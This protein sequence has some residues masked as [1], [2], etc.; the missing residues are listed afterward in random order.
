M[1]VNS[2]DLSH[3]TPAALRSRA[4]AQL[5]AAARELKL[6][7]ALA[8]RE[9]RPT[10]LLRKHPFLVTALAGAA[11][12]TL[13]LLFLRRRPSSVAPRKDPSTPGRAFRRGLAAGLAGG[14]AKLLAD[15]IIGAA[16]R[17]RRR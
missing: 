8:R 14:G 17:R 4:Q 3:L 13:A 6:A 2:D 5:D 12:L 16:R 15:I 9:T 1:I 7:G 11:G 10:R